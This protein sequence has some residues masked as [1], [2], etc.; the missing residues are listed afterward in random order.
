LVPEFL[1]HPHELIIHFKDSTSTTAGHF[2]L[3]EIGCDHVSH[4]QPGGNN[5][6]AA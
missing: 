2:R 1:Q 4:E 3:A 6:C 5:E